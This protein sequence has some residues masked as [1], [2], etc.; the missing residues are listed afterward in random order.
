[1]IS[2]FEVIFIDVWILERRLP[3]AALILVVGQEVSFLRQKSCLQELLRIS[4]FCHRSLALTLIL[5]GDDVASDCLVAIVA[6]LVSIDRKFIEA[7]LA[8]G[9][10]SD[11]LSVAADEVGPVFAVHALK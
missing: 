1:M 10:N 8:D 6:V 2:Q 4:E 9:G 11:F 7:G 3:I 5:D